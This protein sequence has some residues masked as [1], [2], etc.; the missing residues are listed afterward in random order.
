MLY[1]FILEIC[2]RDKG[3]CHSFSNFTWRAFSNEDCWSYPPHFSMEKLLIRNISFYFTWLSRN[4]SPWYY[5][6]KMK[7]YWA[8]TAIDF[9]MV[10]HRNKCCE[11]GP[12]R[13][14]LF[15]QFVLSKGKFT[16][17]W[18][19]GWRVF[20]LLVLAPNL[21]PC[22]FAIAWVGSPHT[23]ILLLAFFYLSSSLATSSWFFKRVLL[24]SWTLES[25]K[26]WTDICC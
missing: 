23:S 5:V 16:K 18:G 19:S 24:N 20:T 9:P 22:P 2:E 11:C 21:F 7:L 10:E 1:L 3:I 4:I 8:I 17:M 6:N 12:S 26:K 13:S 14:F 25:T 15:L